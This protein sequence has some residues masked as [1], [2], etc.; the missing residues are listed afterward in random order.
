MKKY[1]FLYLLPFIF[2]ALTT[3]AFGQQ[4]NPLTIV[5]YGSPNCASPGSDVFT[6]VST[7]SGNLPYTYLWENGSTAFD[8][9]RLGPG[10]YFVT[11]TDARD[12][13][14]RAIIQIA[15]EVVARLVLT[16][17]HCDGDVSGNIRVA[18]NHCDLITVVLYRAGNFS[19]PLLSQTYLANE[20][21]SPSFDV[22]PGNYF[23][24][25]SNGGRPGSFTIGFTIDEVEGF[26]ASVGNTSG[27]DCGESNGSATINTTFGGTSS[28]R[29]GGAG[30]E[31][32][33]LASAY[34][35]WSDGVGTSNNTRNDLAAGSYNVSVTAQHCDCLVDLDVE[36]PSNGGTLTDPGCILDDRGQCTAAPGISNICQEDVG[37]G[38]L[39]N[40]SPG[41]CSDDIPPTYQWYSSINGAERRIIIG[42]NGEDYNITSFS[43]DGNWQFWRRAY[44]SCETLDDGQYTS[45]FTI[46]VSS[47]T[48]SLSA[49]NTTPCV[50]ESITLTANVSGGGDQLFSYNWSYDPEA[51]TRIVTITNPVSSRYQVTVTD[52]QGCSD[53]AFVDIQ[54]AESITSMIV[55][56][57]AISCHDGDDGGFVVSA[58]N[59][60][61]P[62]TYRWNNGVSGQVNTGLSAGTYTVTATDVN[63]CTGA[64]SFTLENPTEISIEIVSLIPPTCFGFTNGSISVTAEGGTPNYS[65]AWSDGQTG[66]TAR[67]LFAGTYSVTVTDA[68][69]CTAIRRITISQ[70]SM[71]IPSGFSTTNVSCRNENDGSATV[72]A[73]GGSPPYSFSWSNGGA[74]NTITNLSAGSYTVTITDSRG[75]STSIGGTVSQPNQN[76]SVTT[77]N[78][79]N[80]SCRNGNDG[81]ITVLASGG[82]SPYT[83]AW[84]TG[85]DG[86]FLTNL[87]AGNYIVTVTDAN[88]CTS[89]IGIPVSQPAE[90]LSVGLSLIDDVNCFGANDGA[91]T[92][93][94]SGGTSPYTYV[95]SN[96]TTGRF[97]TDLPPGNYSVTATDANSC[98][99][100]ISNITINE[101][102][103]IFPTT[104][105]SNASCAGG[106]DGAID[107][108]VFEGTPPYSYQWSHGPTTQDVFNLTA[109]F[110]DVT[111]TDANDCTVVAEGTVDEPSQSLAVTTTSVIN[112]SC[113]NGNDGAIT[114]LASGGT[115]PYTYAW[116]TGANGR[117][118]TNLTAGNYIVTVT[119]ANGCTTG[120]GIPVSQ[121]AES[122]SVGLSLIADV[123]C[124]GANDGAITAMASGGTSPYTY[125]WS[126]GTTG[127][128]NTDLPPGN[129]SVTATDA[130]SCTDVISN[131]TINEPSPIFPTTSISDVSCA[132]GD[133]G[134]INLSVF[135]GTPADSY[136][137]S[138][139]PTTQDVFNLT[140]GFYD[141]TIT[142]ANDCTVVAEGTVD[143][144]SQS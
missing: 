110:Y 103:P 15:D 82:T 66:S 141:V 59:G 28:S 33:V 26:T 132:G 32:G 40:A 57:N 83:Y 88:G 131:I 123:N 19:N 37:R 50:G 69:G 8:R 72:G 144:P 90:G 67:N 54:V 35:S 112:V 47:V 39:I 55:G 1:T 138:H 14:A 64:T 143:E 121:P 61:A 140:A 17:Q 129:Y 137:W 44:C 34:Y 63:G 58:S 87:T 74:G 38:V 124:F 78:V 48:A 116:N 107:L 10:R 94:A 127:R 130:N 73:A 49:S 111:I 109:G 86:R 105:I 42:A 46:D 135:E 136:Q 53:V 115:S 68:Q 16:D 21:N 41:T 104:S 76:L 106:N 99:D 100:V 122:L 25:V 51:S 101:P 43:A 23:L 6:G 11:V 5:P 93:M 2:I 56:G 80:V 75:C 134:A 30:S 18:I 125:V 120:I 31:S 65:Y 36:I 102:S 126:N 13:E 133:D 113:R 91:I 139:G 52:R 128:F 9:G 92:A 119:D 95:W 98:T 3:S 45:P 108:S 142:D 62:Y 4:C 79:T 71:L 60:T 24:E 77:T 117:F 85:A 7:P 20:F 12:Q 118:L 81:A 89:G 84:N 22:D 27:A 29:G 96:G 114:V 70:P 97:N